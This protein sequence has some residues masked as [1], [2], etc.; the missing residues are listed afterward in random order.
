MKLFSLL[1][2]LLLLPTEVLEA[3]PRTLQG[4]PALLH[5]IVLVHG[6]TT[7][8]SSLQVGPWDLGPY[9][10]RIPEFYMTTGTPVMVVHLPTDGSIGER[11]AV[12]K[13]FLETDMR[14]KMV[15]IIGHSLG[16]LDA[17]YAA[18]ILEA[19]QIASITTIGTPH[20]GSPLANWAVRQMN[21][22]TPWYWLFR[23]FGY[24]LRQRR[25]LPELTTDF[26]QNVFNPK[27]RNLTDVRYFSVSTSANFRNHTMSYLLW[28][29]NRWLEGERHPLAA[30]G[31]DGLVPL[32]SQP[33]GREIDRLNLDHLAQMNHHTL[34]QMGF[35]S[36]VLNM[37]TNIYD[38]LLS[39]GL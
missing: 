12:L 26:M 36:E 24:D 21:R 7:K 20:R 8:G 27:V 39:N 16:G 22:R 6:A 34:R 35:E 30:N 19:R 29:P 5:P 28:F 25:F 9:F 4:R 3:S 18:S 14:G 32:D 11:A 31:H 13:N 10:R 23:I 17:R 15:N 37:Y 38:T 2:L 33:W 1:F